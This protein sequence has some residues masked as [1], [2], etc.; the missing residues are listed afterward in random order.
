MSSNNTSTSETPLAAPEAAKPRGARFLTGSTM[1]HILS[2]TFASTIGLLAVFSVDVID[3][4]F[5]SQLGRPEIQTAL[6]FTGTILFATISLGIGLSIAAAATIARA[7]GEGDEATTSRRAVHNLLFAAIFST[8]VAIILFL[9]LTPILKMLGAKDEVLNL[10]ITYLYILIPTMPAFALSIS[11]AAML[12][13]LGDARR[14]AMITIGG[15]AVNAV[16]DPIFIFTLEMGFNGAAIATGIARITMVVLGLWGLLYCH[17][18]PLRIDRSALRAD[19]KA[20]M[21]I[22]VPAILTNVAT[23]IGNAYVTYAAA[24]YG[25]AAVAAWA[26]IA[27]IVPLSFCAVFALSGAI[28]PIIGQNMGGNKINRV[29]ETLTNA[30]KF[31]IIYTVLIWAL[32]AITSPL[33]LNLMQLE[34]TTASIVSYFCLWLSPFFG[35]IGFLF[36]A[37]AA[38]NNLDKPHYSTWL[39]WARATIGTIPFVHLGGHLAGAH[40]LI[41]GQIVGGAIV[42]FLSIFICYRLIGSIAANNP[43]LV[44]GESTGAG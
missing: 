14:S 11:S 30:I 8:F 21:R 1:S 15:G 34:G 20:Y 31:N 44:A 32:L 22:A 13:G 40:G 6:G 35:M 37:N 26:V 23:P 5:L 19:L 33:L 9:I 17:K 7:A 36:I 42:A 24:A 38:F 29:Q 16:L 18:I 2:M 12:R 41:T 27:R 10:S 25:N 4:Y 39:N 3:L 43:A 28:G